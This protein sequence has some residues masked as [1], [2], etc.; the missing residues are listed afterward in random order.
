[1]SFSDAEFVYEFVGTDTEI[2]RQI[3]NAIP[4]RT[5]AALVGAIVA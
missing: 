4:V 1:M 2:T 5:A 3:G